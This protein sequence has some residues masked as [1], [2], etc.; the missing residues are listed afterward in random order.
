MSEPYQRAQVSLEPE[1]R[2]ALQEIAKQEHR[3]LSEVIREIVQR[4]LNERAHAPK[5]RAREALAR[6]DALR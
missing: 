3:S 1:Q 4:Y 5:A 6:L 2:R